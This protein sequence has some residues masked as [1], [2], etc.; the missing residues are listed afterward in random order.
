MWD[1]PR[2]LRTFFRTSCLLTRIMTMKATM[3]YNMYARSLSSS[4][5]NLRRS[6]LPR[7]MYLY[8]IDQILQRQ[9][10][11]MQHF[12]R[13]KNYLN[14]WSSIVNFTLEGIFQC[15][16]ENKGTT[17]HFIPSK[18]MPNLIS[19]FDH[20]LNSIWIELEWFLGSS[21]DN[22]IKYI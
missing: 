6:P 11:N 22:I 8:Y 2:S 3:L 10:F 9:T 19:T 13:L 20:D 14:S 7:E 17:K 18:F 4:C 15:N 21:Y 12:A 5:S 1:L 16:K